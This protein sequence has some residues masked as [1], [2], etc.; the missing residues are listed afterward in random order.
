MIINLEEAVSLL[1]KGHIVA[2]PTETVYGL[3]GNAYN[4]QSLQ[5]IYDIKKRPKNN[6]LIIH[7][8]NIEKIKED[9]ILCSKTETLFEK[10]ASRFWPGPLTLILWKNPKG[11]LKDFPESI[12]VRI[13]AHP[14]IS[15]ILNQLDFPLA[16]PSANPSGY[17]SPTRK[18]H[19]MVNLPEIPIVEGGPCFHG[20][21]STILDLR[22]PENPKILR[23]GAIPSESIFN[24]LELTQQN[25]PDLF[26]VDSK[27][28]SQN[29]LSQNNHCAVNNL[30][31]AY[32]EHNNVSTKLENNFLSE[33]KDQDSTNNF[34][35]IEADNSDEDLLSPGLLLAHYQPKKPLRLL[36]NFCNALP[37]EGL[38]CFGR[39]YDGFFPLVMLSETR[40]LKEMAQNLFHGL[41]ILDEDPRCTCIAVMPFPHEGLGLTILERLKRGS[42]QITIQD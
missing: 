19:V 2:V 42:Q 3:A 23:L 32:F 18:E 24:F 25:F 21:E 4:S 13:P 31:S 22:F 29:F 1:Q 27:K 7:Y 34:P 39:P 10:L 28:E 9:V 37:K 36:S 6:P 33:T 17:L 5:C 35:S 16:A 38:L 30:S 8:G 26:F 41:H 15:K 12:A 11:L 20:L 14:I 40:S